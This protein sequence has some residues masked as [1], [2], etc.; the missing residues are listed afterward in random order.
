MMPDPRNEPVEDLGP[1]PL[2]EDVRS[3]IDAGVAD[4]KAGRTTPVEDP[5]SSS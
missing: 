1:P 3:A 5:P 4:S 2:I